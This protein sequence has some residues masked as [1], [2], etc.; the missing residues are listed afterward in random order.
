M[1]TLRK[2]VDER[3]ARACLLALERSGEVLRVWAKQHGVDGRSLRAW[4]RNLSRRASTSRLP[5]KTHR[6]VELVPISR[7]PTAARRYIVRVGEVAI[8][9]GDDFEADVVRRLIE[10]VRTC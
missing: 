3:D 7:N 10:V 8:E 4:H 6:L 9:L 2:I 1:S 5:S